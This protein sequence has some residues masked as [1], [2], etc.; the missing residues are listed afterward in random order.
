MKERRKV[1]TYGG[2]GRE[3][4]TRRNVKEGKKEYKK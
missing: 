1:T 3:E 2:V 4:R